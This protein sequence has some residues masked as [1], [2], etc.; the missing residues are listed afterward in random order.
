[1]NLTRKIYGSKGFCCKGC[2]EIRQSTC[3]FSSGSGSGRT[4]RTIERAFIR[5]EGAQMITRKFHLAAVAFILTLGALHV[6][7]RGSFAQGQLL[8]SD[9]GFG[10]S[11][12]TQVVPAIAAGA[13]G[14]LIVWQDFRTSPFVG[15]PFS[16]QGRGADIYA[17]R[18]DA[19]GAPSGSPIRIAAAHGD[20]TAPQVAWNGSHWLVAWETPW[21]LWSYSSL[22]QAVRVAPDGAVVDNSPFTVAT[23]AGSRFR[24]TANGTSA[25]GT[26]WL[27]VSESMR[28]FLV[29]PDGALKTPGGTQLFVPSTL[30]FFNVASAN[31]QYLLVWNDTTSPPNNRGQVFDAV[32]NPVGG[33]FYVPSIDVA[34]SGDEYFFAW[35][36]DSTYWADYV[37]GQR[38]KNGALGPV[39]TLAGTGSGLPVWNPAMVRVGWDGT[40]WWAA[41]LE[42]TRGVVFSR[43]AN[44]GNNK[45]LDFGG[46]PVDATAPDR[47]MQ[48]FALAGKQTGGAQFV[49]QD[50]RVTG[51]SSFDIYTAAVAADA[52]PSPR[53]LVSSSGLAQIGIDFAEGPN[54]LLAV[55]LSQVSGATRIV[56]QRWNNSVSP[57][58]PEPFE[59]ATGSGV[60]RPRVGFDG[61]R[62]LVV[63]ADGGQIYGKR[64][65]TSGALIDAAPL[66][67][68]DGSS[69]DVAGLNGKFVVVG[70]R[71]TISAHFVHPFSM[72]VSGSSGATLDAAPVII[73]QY[74]ARNPRVI[75]VAG[76]WLATWQRNFSHDDRNANLMAAFIDPNDGSTP[77]EFIYGYYGGEPDA[78][79]AGDRV[80][81]VW[82][83]GSDSGTYSDIHGRLMDVGVD[84]A[85]L[86][87][88]FII[89]DGSE[90]EVEPAV[91]WNGAD[92]VVAWTD[93][94]NAVVY[95]DERTEVY[96]A[97]VTPDGVV[98]DQAGFA[99]GDRALPELLPAVASI[100]GR[101][102]I[103]M[104]SFRDDPSLQAYRI[105]YEVFGDGSANRWPAAVASATPALGDAALN[106]SFSSLGSYDPEGALLSYEWD[107]GDGTPISTA[108]NPSHSYVNPGEYL[109]QVTVRDASGLA[110]RNVVRVMA[111]PANAGPVAKA[112]ATPD[113]G[114]APLSVVLRAFDAYDPDQGIQ[115]WR[116]D[117][118][119]GG[120]YW[121]STAYHTF[122]SQGDHSA[123]LTVYDFRG[124]SAVTVIPISVGPP[125]GPPV[126]KAAATPTS[127]PAP[128]TVGFSSAGSY[129][130]EGA[131]LSYKWNFGDG[132]I[133]TAENPN[134]TYATPGIY[135][136]TLTVTDNWGATGS[137]SLEVTATGE[138]NAAVNLSAKFRGGQ[139]NVT[140]QVTVTD[141][142]SGAGVAGALVDATWETPGGSVTQSATTNG[143]GVATFT[144][145]GPRGDYKLTVNAVTKPAYACG[146]GCAGVSATISGSTK[147]GKK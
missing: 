146:A 86:G 1:M 55:F 18:L 112:V 66:S 2:K 80:L 30:I 10:A 130:P 69:P 7:T 46:L 64:V 144:T 97:R 41:W 15:P 3:F 9:N 100:G 4:G 50:G 24:L 119:D 89:S 138:L 28:G 94:R 99:V 43:V 82:R 129:D 88:P 96:G 147:G 137:A 23:N 65:S 115:N 51:E 103:A 16:S 81:F 62:Y 127:G 25:S 11:I 136:V 14:Y 139:L 12:G 33:S 36:E 74:F 117:F 5:R 13:N 120:T 27:V 123:T 22:I 26:D 73:G 56:A 71:P 48:A 57:I 53:E 122:Y 67:I 77:G 91:G 134:H 109:A 32:L 79:A 75:A 29:A 37:K 102:I 104:S 111:T 108:A 131:P 17:L 19:T 35:V 114:P 70:R 44:I 72:R 39:V 59:I 31:G 128:L 21:E 49:W 78:A 34:S 95:F 40:N 6:S 106:V 38:L 142:S 143:S 133:S 85:V 107:F 90:K 68:M 47:G 105:Y 52:V 140:G 83:T 84:S 126:A 63:W 92:F 110:T 125:N 116:W 98:I 118:S 87:D 8:P 145:S 61:T 45:V 60:S 121:G 54:Q 93:Q 124:A 76:R 20:Q 101:T 135:T 58:D 132:V 141:K 113:S 42:T